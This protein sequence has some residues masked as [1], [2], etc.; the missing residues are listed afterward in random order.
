MKT[1]IVTRILFLIVLA[2]VTS[3]ATSA[4]LAQRAR[5]SRSTAQAKAAPI[6]V[7]AATTRV[8]T[9]EE[10]LAYARA[11]AGRDLHAELESNPQMLTH[12]LAPRFTTTLNGNKVDVSAKALLFDRREGVSFMWALRVY[13]GE[14]RGRKPIVEKIYDH[15]LTAVPVGKVIEPTFTESV[16]LPPGDYQVEV[17]LYAFQ[18]DFDMSKV[19]ERD[20]TA[21]PTPMGG[22]RLVEV[23]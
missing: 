21:L 1:S 20:W 23:R 7:P 11:N 18:P 13:D 22:R 15:Q 10:V 2:V 12:S 4:M 8:A 3:L 14:V 9:Q 5:R 19:D 6:P 17:A 16:E